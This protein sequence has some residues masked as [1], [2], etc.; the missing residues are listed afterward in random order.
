MR[1]DIVLHPFSILLGLVL[2]VAIILLF[3]KTNRDDDVF[4]E[5][6][7]PW[8]TIGKARL[9][10]GVS[11]ILAVIVGGVFAY[12]NIEAA[13]ND[14][15][16]EN[17]DDTIAGLSQQLGEKSQEIS[18]LQDTIRD[19]NSAALQSAS[20]ITALDSEVISLQSKLQREKEE[21]QD[22][23]NALA[24]KD[25]ALSRL[26]V[27]SRRQLNLAEQETIRLREQATALEQSL[28]LT[29]QNNV[30]LEQQLTDTL[31]LLRERGLS[32]TDRDFLSSAAESIE[33]L[34]AGLDFVQIRRVSSPV[35]GDNVDWPTFEIVSK[36]GLLA[37]QPGRGGGLFS[38]Y[39]QSYQFE[40]LYGDGLANAISQ[41]IDQIATELCRAVS[42]ALTS[43]ARTEDVLAE[44]SVWQKYT[45][46][47]TFIGRVIETEYLMQRLIAD[48]TFVDFYATGYAD[49]QAG[50]WQ[51]DLPRDLSSGYVH[52]RGAARN[53]PN[54]FVEYF[55][56]QETT[57]SLGARE[58]GRHVYGNAQ[59]PNLR[60]HQTRYLLDSMAGACT[61][62]GLDRAFSEIGQ[63]EGVVF[64]D[65]SRNDRKSRVHFRIRMTR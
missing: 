58:N 10:G 35:V 55:Q 32:Q 13:I 33:A 56:E 61:G 17:R 21:R 6:S 43:S 60:G 20:Q 65:I 12:P 24:E 57:I 1:M 36:H 52:L 62:P 22:A 50:S 16:V 45:E 23:E 40:G 64:E 14:E 11:L 19:Q 5:T 47:R 49:G 26:E 53:Q 25:A 31:I 34:N 27:E 39:E 2:I 8:F 37:T 38:F 59:L 28:S 4:F 18:T 41:D 7:L 46:D 29:R 42:T 15:L 51:S 44:T 54:Q 9:S 48:Y 63:L 3:R 30:S